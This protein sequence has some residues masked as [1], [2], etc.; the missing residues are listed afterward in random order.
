MNETE[1]TDPV[2]LKSVYIAG[3]MRGIKHYNFDAFFNAERYMER[4]GAACVVNPAREDLDSG[5]IGFDPRDVDVADWNLF[6]GSDG[7]FIEVALRDIE[8]LSRCETICMLEGYENSAGAKAELAFAKWIGLHEVY[9]SVKNT[10]PVEYRWGKH[11]ED[12]NLPDDLQ[13]LE[14]HPFFAAWKE[15]WRN[16]SC[17]H[18]KKDQE[19][20]LQEAE[21]L[22]YGDRNAQYG[23]PTQDFDRTAKMWSAL[24]GAEFTARDVA[25]FMIC[26]KLSRETHQKKRD[27]WVDMAGYADCGSRC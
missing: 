3:P 27:N 8:I 18:E 19:T 24:K 23:P 17:A 4:M 7:D 1:C 12:G 25:M 9:Q 21:R 16:D 11:S 13:D 26:L 22:V 20:I 6:P 14:E 15:I 5:S 10:G 2:K